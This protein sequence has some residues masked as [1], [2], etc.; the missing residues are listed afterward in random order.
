VHSVIS[1]CGRDPLPV[2]DYTIGKMTVKMASLFWCTH[3]DL[4]MHLREYV[5]VE[6]VNKASIVYKKKA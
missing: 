3:L 4:L 2:D 1:H 5:Q 6:Q